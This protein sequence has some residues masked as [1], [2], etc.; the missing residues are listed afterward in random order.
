MVH[1]PFAQKASPRIS[2]DI[3]PNTRLRVCEEI[4]EY[5]WSPAPSDDEQE[6]QLEPYMPVM[7]HVPSAWNP[8]HKIVL[9]VLSASTKERARRKTTRNLAP[10]TMVVCILESTKN[11]KLNGIAI[12]VPFTTMTMMQR[13]R[14]RASPGSWRVA[15][16]PRPNGTQPKA[17]N[18]ILFDVMTQEDLTRVEQALHP[19]PEQ[20]GN[21]STLYNNEDDAEQRWK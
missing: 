5:L 3:V 12:Q 1:V 19:E 8:I 7:R 14:S 2:P 15:K 11:K 10:Q 13:R 20:R 6:A 16:Q 9:I 17:K 21:L 4:D 18:Q